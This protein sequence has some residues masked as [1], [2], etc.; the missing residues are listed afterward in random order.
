MTDILQ[1]ATFTKIEPLNKGW[2]SD[3]KYY[4]E[5]ADGERLLLR[6]ADVAE[7]ERKRAEFDMLKR[8]AELDVPAS[9]PVA[10]GVCD[11][12]KSV[13][14]LLTW[15]DGEDATEVLHYYDETDQYVLGYRSGEIL[16]KIHSILAPDDIEDWAIRFNRKTDNKLKTYREC[17]LRFDGDD[18]VIAYL[19][20]NRHLLANRPQCY[21]HGDYHVGNMLISDAK[22]LVIID[23]NRDAYGDPWEEFNRIV[24]SA[25]C[26]LHFATGQLRGYFSAEPPL[27][28]W[29]LLA[30]YIGSNTLSSVYW[31]IPFGQGEIDTMIK[32]SQDVLAWYDNMQ[33]PIPSWYLQDYYY[34]QLQYIDDVPFK[35]KS[36]F[37]LEFVH[38]YGAVFKVFDG[39]DSGNLCFGVE[40]DGK[41]YFVKFAG[42]P[43]AQY[44]GEIA[45]AIEQLK[46]TAPI[47]KDLAHPSLIHFVKAEEIGGGFAMV[48]EWVDAICAHPMYPADYQK[49]RQLS[50]E[51]KAQIFGEIMEFMAFVAERG[52]VAID[53]YDGSIMWDSANERTVICDIDFFQKSPYVGRMGLWGSSRFVSPEERTDGA[54]IDEVTNVYTLGATAF[55]MFA[56]SARSH[57]AWTFSDAQ[58]AVAKRATSDNRDERQQSIRQLIEEWRAVE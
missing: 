37:D 39:Q 24:W 52:Y 6:V 53:F 7:Y 21:Q 28:F 20:A 16:R 49:F 33:N 31:A 8:I 22:T 43:T 13:Y 5:T 40:K 35:L 41:R 44:D 25:Q 26:S 27:E 36:P 12:G 32:Q 57:E 50:I 46:E 10:F 4:V 38:R 15:I 18:A 56:D 19:N 14:Q 11:G 47:Y 29:Q 48:F 42:A 45:D 17:G 34:I 2:S 23:W 58:Y 30:F 9:R 3:K 55:A 1:Y 51:I 54:V